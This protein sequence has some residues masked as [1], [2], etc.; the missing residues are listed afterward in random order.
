MAGEVTVRRAL[1]SPVRSQLLDLL[2]SAD[3]ALTIEVLAR[4]LELHRNTVRGHLEVLEIAGLVEHETGPPDG[5]GRPRSLFR[6]A[7]GVPASADDAGAGSPAG[8]DVN[9]LLAA[10]LAARVGDRDSEVARAAEDAAR[11]WAR[12]HGAAD[13]RE[14]PT[15]ATDGADRLVAHLQQWGFD[16]VTDDD[17]GEGQQVTLHFR[18]CPLD[19]VATV[20]PQLACA[21]HRGLTNG[22]LEALGRPLDVVAL[23]PAEATG[24]CTA[25]L[26]RPW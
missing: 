16:T 10:L 4:R 15:G 23:T 14:R 25:R 24:R 3:G 11:Q 8:E 19:D 7:Q 12:R 20:N 13:R 17:A 2:L 21:V 9:R 22:M 5:P 1:A 26:E 18:G 6:P